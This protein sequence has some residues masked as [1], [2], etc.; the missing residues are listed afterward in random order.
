MSDNIAALQAVVDRLKFEL[1]DAQDAL[2][3]AKIE[4]CGVAIGDIVESTHWR[5]AGTRFRVCE[6]DVR[7]SSTWVKGNPALKSGGWGVSARQLF[8]DWVK[9]Q[10]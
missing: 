10:S 9:V 5:N 3:R 8:N 1:T 2:T 6:I 4:R 7:F